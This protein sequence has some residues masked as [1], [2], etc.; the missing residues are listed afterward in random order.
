M[1]WSQAACVLALGLDFGVM[2]ADRS[3]ASKPLGTLACSPFA[4]ARAPAFALAPG[5]AMD[6]KT[7]LYPVVT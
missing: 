3:L 7:S 6:R 2:R 1:R 5:R 4:P